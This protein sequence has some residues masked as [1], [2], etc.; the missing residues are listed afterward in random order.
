[1][2]I[3][4]LVPHATELLFALGCGDELIAITHECDYPEATAAIPKITRDALPP[5]ASA[6]EIDA[7]VRDRTAAGRSIYELDDKLLRELAPD[8][9]VTQALCPVCAVSYDEVASL[10]EEIPSCRGVV[11][12]DP[13]T[14]G[15]T[16][17]DV[18]TLAQLTGRR[19]EGLD[20]VARSAGRIDRVRLAVRGAGR[21]AVAAI[22][23]FDPL[24][25][26]GHWVPQMI[27]WAGG[28]DVLG[29]PGEPSAMVGWADVAAA[30]PELVLAMPCG[31][32]A[33]RAADEARA[34]AVELRRTGAERVIAV[35][36]SSYF[37]RPGPRLVDGLEL[38]AHILH[39]DLVPQTPAA[40]LNVGLDAV[41]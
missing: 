32:G 25:I 1:M 21:P 7:M 18:R 33:E 40:M 35:D 26:G 4:S 24:F 8:L 15:E 14:I 17:A 22:E 30:R 27:E 9:I 41:A 19:D 12:L 38:L 6:A 20:L 11:A 28:H 31:Y 3:V 2:R 36:A 10:A 29:L 37:S 39:P 16:L 5:G 34:H 23:W 13:H